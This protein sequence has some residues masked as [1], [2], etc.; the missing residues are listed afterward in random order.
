MG[1]GLY[2]VNSFT[3]RRIRWIHVNKGPSHHN[4]HRNASMMEMCHIAMYA[5]PQVVHYS[6][7]SEASKPLN[8]AL[9]VSVFVVRLVMESVFMCSF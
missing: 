5:N 3:G 4:V 2:D 1:G 9:N 7:F 6:A 8:V